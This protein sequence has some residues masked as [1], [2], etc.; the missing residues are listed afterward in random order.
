[1]LETL[2]CV[3]IDDNKVISHL[4]FLYLFCNCFRGDIMSITNSP[5]IHSGQ[6]FLRIMDRWTSTLLRI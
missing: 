2:N 5:T 3:N 6:V 1:M 4:L